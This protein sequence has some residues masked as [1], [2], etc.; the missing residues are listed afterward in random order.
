MGK[1]ETYFILAEKYYVEEQ[2]P[3]STIAT[4]LNITAKTL[5][6]WKK[7]GDW[8]NK[9][10]KFLQ[11]QY[12]CYASLY[13]LVNKMTQKISDDYANGISPDG[14]TLYFISKMTDKLP[15]LKKFET[16]LITDKNNQEVKEKEFSEEIIKKINDHIVNGG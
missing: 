3:V 6:E 10:M 8:E 2:L 13:E 11:S 15:K 9:R 16:E 5:G 14:S 12:N 1:K 4:R 7:E